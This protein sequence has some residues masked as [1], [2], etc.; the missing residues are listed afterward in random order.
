MS[1]VAALDVER[2]DL[3][4]TEFALDAVGFEIARSSWR[5]EGYS[6]TVRLRRRDAAHADR[7]QRARAK[8]RVTYRAAPRRGLYFL[9]PDEHVQ[10]R[11]RQ[12]W[13]QCQ[14]EDARHFSRATT[15]RTSR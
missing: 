4:A 5:Q 10:H 11:P 1:G 14:D 6:K 3:S 12:V 2:V 8:L 13:T 9:A 7:R 15:S